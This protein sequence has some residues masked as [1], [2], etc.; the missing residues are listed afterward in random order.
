MLYADDTSFCKCVRRFVNLFK[1][2]VKLANEWFLASNLK[3]NDG[4][5]VNLLLS[6]H[7]RLA[8]NVTV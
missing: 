3:L 4:E 7:I 2:V 8:L 5:T 1:A 6:S